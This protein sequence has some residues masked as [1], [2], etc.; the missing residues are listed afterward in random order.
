M[1]IE[2]LYLISANVEM[3][4]QQLPFISSKSDLVVKISHSINYGKHRYISRDGPDTPFYVIQYKK[5]KTSE[6]I[7]LLENFKVDVF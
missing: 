7:N 4:F 2:W 3:S 6:E 1:I 5:P